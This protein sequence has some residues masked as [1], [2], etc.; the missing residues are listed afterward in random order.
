MSEK[1]TYEELFKASYFEDV[2]DGSLSL[3]TYAQVL[4]EL[5]IKTPYFIVKPYPSLTV[6]ERVP[7]EKR[8]GNLSHGEWGSKFLTNILNG[9]RS[10]GNGTIPTFLAFFNGD[11]TNNFP[12]DYIVEWM[13]KDNVPMVMLTAT[14]IGMD[15]KGGQ[16]GIEFLPGGKVR[17]CKKNN[18]RYRRYGS[19]VSRST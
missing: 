9:K 10:D 13:I 1:P 18:I 16:I 7:T 15:I 2:R 17:R 5:E 4:E 11:G 12:D 19:A 14:K 6:K 3:R 8:E